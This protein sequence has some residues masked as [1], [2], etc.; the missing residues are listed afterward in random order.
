MIPRTFAGRPRAARFAPLNE[1]R[2]LGTAQDARKFA[3]N[4]K[5]EATLHGRKRIEPLRCIFGP[6]GNVLTIADLPSPK[7]KR[8]V[9]RRKTEV[10]LAVKGGFTS[11]HFCG[12]LRSHSFCLS[13]GLYSFYS[14]TA[15][16][17]G[18][19]EE[20]L[21]CGLLKGPRGGLARARPF[22]LPQRNQLQS[23]AFC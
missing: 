1:Q 17:D 18:R 13:I 3:L 7:T 19:L 12:E 2:A 4:G 14:P 11:L 21:P 5:E 23:S 16:R 20:A 9:R 10:V 15:L 8:W 6:N 22:S